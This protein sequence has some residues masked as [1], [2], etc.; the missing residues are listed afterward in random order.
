VSVIPHWQSRLAEVLSESFDFLI[1]SIRK[2]TKFRETCTIFF[3][4][5]IGQVCELTIRGISPLYQ[6][7]DTFCDIIR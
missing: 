5:N 7:E 6:F 2:I 1:Y 3:V 4:E